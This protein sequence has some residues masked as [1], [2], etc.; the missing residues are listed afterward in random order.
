MS[1]SDANGHDR[2][3]GAPGEVGSLAG[4]VLVSP[5]ALTDPNFAWTVVLL[6]AHNPEGALGL[7]LNR[8]TPLAV[9]E[10]LPAWEGRT[11]LPA[12]VFRGGPVDPS[13]VVALG[14]G[15]SG[16]RTG[17]SQLLDDVGTVDLNVDPDEVGPLEGLRVFA[18]YSGWGA[19]QLEGELAM[20]AWLVCAAH[21][22]DVVD[23]DPDTLWRRVLRREGGELAIVA[24]HP[25]DISGN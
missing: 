21:P 7:V 24:L 25:R 11:S 4:K 10:I 2:R 16:D 14:P 9:A 5:P 12:Q 13:T 22:D 15:R 18:G 23:P 8:P 17:W 3:H 6:L 19:G 20:G 1:E